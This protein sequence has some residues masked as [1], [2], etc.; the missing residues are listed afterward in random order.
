MPATG[1]RARLTVLPV[2]L[3]LAIAITV[4]VVEPLVLS[5]NLPQVSR[6]LHA[7][8][9]VLGLLGGA[10]TLVVA[11]PVLAAGSLGDIV[12]LKR[13]LTSGDDAATGR[14]G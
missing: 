7:P 13:L 3:A 2:V 9:H 11:A 8:P 4:T 10:A 1:S 5:L 12:G 6:A 14:Q